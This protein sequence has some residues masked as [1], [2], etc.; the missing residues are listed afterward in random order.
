VVVVHG[1]GFVGGWRDMPA[2]RSVVRAGLQAGYSV[3]CPDYRLVFRGGRFAE[4]TEDLRTAWRWV[5][6]EDDRLHGPYHL[7]GIS[8]G[9]ALAAAVATELEPASLALVY[10]PLDF[11]QLPRW[12]TRA[13]LRTSEGSLEA[14]SP[15]HNCLTPAPTL[16][17][18]GQRDVLCP[19]SHSERL[20]Q[21]REAAGHATTFETFPNAGHGFLNWPQDPHCQQAVALL[22]AWLHELRE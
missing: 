5:Q 7:I 8:A 9:A 14:L 2:V 20:V 22:R 12:V 18:H 16:V 4:A 21:Q 11:T 1:G 15:A 19:I 13:L 6:E 10:G 3:V 17:L